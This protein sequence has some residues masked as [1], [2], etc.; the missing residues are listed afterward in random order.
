MRIFYKKIKSRENDPPSGCVLREKGEVCRG[1]GGVRVV[2]C[3]GVCK[4]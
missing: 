2:E 1:G 4:N 3:I